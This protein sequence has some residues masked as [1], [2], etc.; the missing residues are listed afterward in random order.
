MTTTQRSIIFYCGIPKRMTTRYLKYKKITRLSHTTGLSALW[1]FAVLEKVTV[2][3]RDTVIHFVGAI[4]SECTQVIRNCLTNRV[5][6]GAGFHLDFFITIGFSSFAISFHAA[7]GRALKLCKRQKKKK[8]QHLAPSRAPLK[9]SWWL[10][11]VDDSSNF[12]SLS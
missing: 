9:W 3:P 2:V 11:K 8:R 7:T 1:R 4:T 5:L 6:L 10:M 12:Q